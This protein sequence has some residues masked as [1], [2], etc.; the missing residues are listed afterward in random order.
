MMERFFES[1]AVLPFANAIDGV[2]TFIVSPA[3]VVPTLLANRSRRPGI[4][5]TYLS[6]PHLRVLFFFLITER[7]G[8]WAEAYSLANE[9]VQQLTLDEKLGLVIG[10]GQFGS[11]F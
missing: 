9:T 3:R 8:S 11:T 4:H 1:C 10:V 6:H 5:P 7:P 2:A